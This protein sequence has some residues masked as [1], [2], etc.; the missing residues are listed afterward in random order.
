MKTYW[1]DLRLTSME[2]EVFQVVGNPLFL[3]ESCSLQILPLCLCFH[4]I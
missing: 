2:V 4:Y 1:L 3:R